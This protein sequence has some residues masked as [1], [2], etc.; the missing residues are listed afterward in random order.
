MGSPHEAQRI[1]R[2]TAGGKGSQDSGASASDEEVG[3]GGRSQEGWSHK[4]A[5]RAGEQRATGQGRAET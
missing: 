5:S 1:P 4:K 3:G 2:G